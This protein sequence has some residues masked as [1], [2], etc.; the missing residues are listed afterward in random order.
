M[1]IQASVARP[2]PCSMPAPDQKCVEVLDRSK[3]S[4]QGGAEQFRVGDTRPGAWWVSGMAEQDVDGVARARRRE[5]RGRE[6]SRRRV[7]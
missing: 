7:G 4:G 1:S 6:P 3:A 2:M 5:R